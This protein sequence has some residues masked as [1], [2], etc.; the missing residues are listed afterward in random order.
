[1][2]IAPRKPTKFHKFVIGNLSLVIGA[3]VKGISGGLKEGATSFFRA[4]A[5]LRAR[6]SGLRLQVFG[7]GKYGFGL[8]LDGKFGNVANAE[9]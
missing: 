7:Q 8:E 3:V 1:M 6:G 5:Q 4:K 2:I 9:K